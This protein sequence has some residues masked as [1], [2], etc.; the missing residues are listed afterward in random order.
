MHRIYH[1]ALAMPLATGGLALAEPAPLELPAG[2]QVTHGEALLQ[3]GAGRL[4][5][6]QHSDQ[7]VLDWQQFNIGRDAIVEFS[8]PS[9]SSVALNRVLSSDPSEIFGRLIANGQVFLSNP[10]GVIFGEGSHVDV[11][12]LVATSMRIGTEDFMAGRYR[13]TNGAGA[14]VNQGELHAADG[15]FLALMAPEVRNE[16]VLQANL[17][18]VALAA[19]EA[20]TLQLEGDEL[21]LQV[22]PATVD[23]LLENR[24]LIA[25]P[26]GQVILSASAGERL[27][28]GAIAGETGATDLVAENGTVRLVNI[29]GTV[30]GGRIAIDGGEVGVTRVAGILDASSTE[31]NGGDIQV[32]GDKV[33]IDSGAL[34]DASGHQG[35]TA[36]V[37]GHNTQRVFIDADAA[38]RADGTQDGGKVIVY[39]QE[40]TQ[41][42][43][44]LSARGGLQGGDG[45]FIETSGA[46]LDLRGTPDVS[47]PTGR[48]GNW[49]IDPY[50]ITIQAAGSDTS[51]GSSPNWQSTANSAILT[52][53]SVQ[54]A[55]DAGTNVTITTGSAGT[56]GGDITISDPITKT[57]GGAASLTLNAHRDI[58]INA[59][60]STSSNA[61]SL[62][63]NADSDNDLAGAIVLTSNL[64]TLG[65][66]INF[67]D[68]TVI[69][70]A[71]ALSINTSG[72]SGGDVSFGDQVMIGNSNGVTIT[73]G[74]GDVSFASLIDSGNSYALVAPT[75][76]WVAARTAAASGSGLNVG[77]T[78]LATIT[79]PLEMSR[80]ASAA[81]YAGAWLG[82]ADTTTEGTWRWVT[83][84]EGL[85]DGGLGRII[86]VGNRVGQPALTGYNGYNGAYVNWNAGEPN[87]FGGNEDALELGFGPAG[88]WNDFPTTGALLP[89]VRET[90]LAPSPLTISAGT[91]NITFNGDVGVNKALGTLTLSNSGNVFVN[92][93]AVNIFGDINFNAGGAA[94]I[95]ASNSPVLYAD[96]GAI[97]LARSIEKNAGADAALTLRADTDVL[98]TGGSDITSTNGR[99][100]VTLNSDRDASGAGVISL[101]S[102]TTLSSNG[103]AITLRGG[104]SA[105]SAVADPTSDAAGFLSTLTSTGARGSGSAGI[106]LSGAAINA[107]GGNVDLRGV[108][109]ASNKGVQI[110]DG[111]LVTT[112]GAGT[113]AIH[114]VGGASGSESDGVQISSSTTAVSTQSG[115]LRL[116][117]LGRGSS[118][119]QGVVVKTPLTA[120]SPTVDSGNGNIVVRGVSTATGTDNQ[121]VIVL[122]QGSLRTTGSG[123]IDVLGRASGTTSGV[124]VHLLDGATIQT[125]GGGDLSLTGYG[126]TIGTVANNEGVKV[127]DSLVEV[128]TGSSADLTLLGFGGT[129]Q[130]FNIGV[131]VRIDG[132]VRMGAT[133]GGLMSI[134]GTGGNGSVT[135]NWGVLAEGNGIYESLGA[136]PIRITGIGGTG[137]DNPG[138]RVTGGSTNRIG[139]STMTGDITLIADTMDLQGA[140]V[141]S[142]R[143]SGAL[144]VQPY[145][146]AT[147]IGVGN[148]ASGTLNLN[149]TELSRF[150][151]GF[152]QITIGRTD[153]TGAINVTNPTFNDSLRLL[154]TGVGAAGINLGGALNLGA[155]D[156]WLA[157]DGPITQ[158]AAISA[159]RLLLTGGSSITLTNAGNAVNTLAGVTAGPL[160]FNNSSSL[161]I[162]S[163]VGNGVTYNGLQSSGN[164]LTVTASGASSD[165]TLDSTVG[166]VGAGTTVQLAAGRNFINNAGSSAIN[167]GGGRWLVWSTDPAADT[168]GGLAYDFKHYGATYGVTTPGQSTGNGFLY[169]TAPTITASLTGTTSR[170]YDGT[171]N[172]ALTSANFGSSGA[173]DGDTIL[174]NTPST[175]MFDTKNVG[176]GKTVTAAGVSI[177]NATNGSATVYGYQLA[178]STLSGAIGEITA[179]ALTAGLT[180]SVSKTYDST[181]AATL[182]SANYTL[183][184]VLGSEDVTLNEP[185]AGTYDTQNA[186]TGK[187]VTV[188]GVALSG[189]DAGNY[190]LGSSTLSGAVGTI[191]PKALTV[192]ANDSSRLY[193]DANPAFRATYNGFVSGED[194]SVLTQPLEF[195]TAA[196]QTSDAGM[197]SVTP[198]S[199]TASN[200]SISFVPGTLTVNPAPLLVTADDQTKTYGDTDPTLTVTVGGAGLRN[201]DILSGSLTAPTGTAATAGTHAI[202]Q[203]TLA[204]TSNYT[205]AFEP[206]TLTVE[207]APL[208]IIADDKLRDV[209]ADNPALTSTI[210]GLQYGEDRSVISGLTLGTTAVTSS[211]PGPY[212]IVAQ[213]ASAS[214]YSISY[215]QGT[216]LVL[217]DS[218]IA[219]APDVESAIS[220]QEVFTPPIATTDLS[221]RATVQPVAAVNFVQ[222]GGVATGTTADASLATSMSAGFIAVEELGT[223]EIRERSAIQFTLP[224]DTFRHSDPNAAIM[225]SVTAAD[226]S[227]LPEW[228]SYDATSETLTGVPPQDFKGMDVTFIAR[229][230]FGGE[231]STTIRLREISR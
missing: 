114:G 158:S 188:S 33:H 32:T 68:G 210:H 76:S 175:G 94:I 102:G 69:G 91:G 201:G 221:T 212:P 181:T 148:S 182:N 51:I 88:Q 45:G 26:G 103:G 143:S 86:N 132:I 223:L 139:S 57:A 59:A 169:S 171:T 161:S 49:L 17:G 6:T 104:S 62:T 29:E 126:S 211:V 85:E 176:T 24:Q 95:G 65:G 36:L 152:S 101:A 228:L 118:S 186:G 27:R 120:S 83:G 178:S 7:A 81:G 187:T 146:A 204:A 200:Y 3:E 54:S 177:A 98:L 78:F 67:L 217:P 163:I 219:D 1:F 30:Q 197:Y 64:T 183:T 133:A 119:S 215:M 164:T 172:A 149:S 105:L 121:G 125:T 153:G 117:G 205:L 18:T 224:A 123:N 75:I 77:D 145:S 70:G 136:A 203:G 53:A 229:D 110:D 100:D 206:G 12:G 61:L 189:A 58:A 208:L 107:G 209:F 159:N 130:S 122:T 150:A 4:D 35:G 231:A 218:A 147:S 71:S 195:N 11:G 23:V 141:I 225:I 184:G 40:G 25:A 193:G 50:N 157:S 82:G 170:T 167:P 48:A 135:G 190:T 34:L 165:L 196:N 168:R 47:A 52:T 192:T 74:G 73:T 198:G 194:S 222:G 137:A 142:V 13:F 227:P 113:V 72:G 43:G 28:E 92:A 111:S 89:Y 99:L 154:N 226:G 115:E 108:G 20:V 63:F 207:R 93:N 134:T 116:Q 84:P 14:V 41:I 220:T 44:A 96:D 39:S 55:L 214:N 191:L 66:S 21:S 90:V 151:D 140:G 230:E 46:W 16:G 19:G 162:G 128:Q 79:S 166:G 127:D 31:D 37:G 38:I 60:I 185:T 9:A 109:A 56:Q 5:V 179:L 160:S 155:N 131:N 129:G 42:A 15:G 216:L 80:A 124:G 106:L 202:E 87:D 2:G 156:L 10:N 199:A 180:G 8:Q 173:I 138:I 97:N 213:G 112:T 174:L 22:D 144:N